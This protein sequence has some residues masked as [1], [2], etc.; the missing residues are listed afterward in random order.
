MQEGVKGRETQKKKEP[1]LET[2]IVLEACIILRP[3][4]GELEK[5]VNSVKLVAEGLSAQ[6][7][8]AC[9][10]NGCDILSNSGI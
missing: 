5:G 4:D 1:V 2:W 3:S 6:E 7:Q 10:I 9:Q 8:S